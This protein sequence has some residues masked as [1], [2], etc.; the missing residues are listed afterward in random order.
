MQAV[1]FYDAHANRSALELTR[2]I[3]FF[4]DVSTGLLGCEPSEL[5]LALRK[6]VELELAQ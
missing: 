5:P 6:C 3:L 2:V 1:C 4:S